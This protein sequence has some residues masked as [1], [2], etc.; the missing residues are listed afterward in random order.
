MPPDAHTTASIHAGAGPR[1]KATPGA[2]PRR[3]A[4][5]VADGD[6]RRLLHEKITRFAIRSDD[7]QGDAPP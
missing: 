4:D 3:S 2:W 6:R 5:L 1:T 7:L